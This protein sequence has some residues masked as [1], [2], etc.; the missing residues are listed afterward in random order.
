MYVLAIHGCSRNNGP[1]LQL[2][3]VS[4]I[5][6]IITGDILGP[7]KNI[8]KKK[9][10]LFSDSLFIFTYPQQCSKLTVRPARTFSRPCARFSDVC[11]QRAHIYSPNYNCNILEECTGKI[12]GAQFQYECT[13][14]AHKIKP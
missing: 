3:K 2:W 7:P 11:A 12:P 10:F 6:P 8:L 14:G 5:Q 1:E 4:L 9:D 13:R